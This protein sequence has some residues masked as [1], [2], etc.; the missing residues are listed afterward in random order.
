MTASIG[1][2][3]EQVSKIRGEVNYL[4]TE[5]TVNRRFVGKGEVLKTGTYEP[6][7]INIHDGRP[8]RDHFNL[9]TEGFM[10]LDHRSSVKDFTDRNELDEVY[11]DEVRGEVQ[12]IT[13]ADQVVAMGYV[14]RRSEK[15]GE[16]QSQ[17]PG[18]DVHVDMSATD[19]RRRFDDAYRE[20][21]PDGPGYKR[22]LVTSFWRTFSPAPQDWPLAVAQYTSLDDAEGID[23]H[24]VFVDELPED[25]Y[26]DLDTITGGRTA[27]AGSAFYY[28]AD[29]RW[30]YF[31]NMN[32]DEVIFFKLNDTDTTGPWRV[33]HS[34]F[35]DGTVSV[36]HKRES[37]EVRTIAFWE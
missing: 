9:D 31:P 27:A 20:N 17:P 16:V 4:S 37:V 26:A 21:F 1:E 6:R 2:L 25:P 24:M 12:R 29:H 8:V 34:A 33:M 32:R 10:L 18:N 35:K 22:A 7:E 28:S 15:P 11:L 13:G 23:T 14:V 19:A 3:S 30:W 5:T 36:D